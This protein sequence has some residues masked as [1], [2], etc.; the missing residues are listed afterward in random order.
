M[1]FSCVNITFPELVLLLTSQNNLLGHIK[2]IVIA[3]VSQ[4]PLL[5]KAYSFGCGHHDNQVENRPSPYLV[6]VPVFFMVQ[7]V[8]NQL[9]VTQ[10][11]C[12]INRRSGACDADDPTCIVCMNCIERS[13]EVRELS[14]CS[15]V[16]H[17]DCLDSWIDHGNITCPLCKS[18]LLPAQ[19]NN[20]RF[21]SD[22]WRRE[23]MIYLFGEDEMMGTC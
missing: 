2:A 16:F 8:K 13:H 9:P 17:R 4:I 21:G 7:S 19:G 14:S 23:R 10:Y 11:S 18:K 12:F 3:V 6:P 22:P 1:G 5:G 15:H 20:S